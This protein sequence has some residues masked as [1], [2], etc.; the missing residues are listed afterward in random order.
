MGWLALTFVN[1]CFVQWVSVIH[2]TIFVGFADIVWSGPRGRTWFDLVD[3]S[4]DLSGLNGGLLEHDGLI[5]FVLHQHAIRAGG[6]A[7]NVGHILRAI[8]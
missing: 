6:H 5:L 4:M 7:L 1:L 2:H 8:Q 3:Y